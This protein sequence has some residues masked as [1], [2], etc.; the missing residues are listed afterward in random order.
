MQKSN[1]NTIN[2]G[3]PHSLPERRSKRGQVLK[4]QLCRGFWGRWFKE[5]FSYE[6]G[7]K[8]QDKR[9]HGNLACSSQREKKIKEKRVKGGENG[10][11]DVVT[12]QTSEGG[13]IP[14]RNPNLSP[15]G[16]K[17]NMKKPHY[18]SFVRRALWLE[19]SSDRSV[20]MTARIPAGS[21]LRWRMEKRSEFRGTRSIPSPGG[22]FAP[23]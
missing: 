7:R 6:T 14:D 21:W 19:R 2:P 12:P 10:L 11:R 1:A 3:F 17:D 22:L 20:P 9:A 13:Y 18:I 4:H 23:K 16:K 15:L 8:L 5:Y